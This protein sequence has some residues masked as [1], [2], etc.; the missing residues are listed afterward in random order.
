VGAI[1]VAL[2]VVLGL[3]GWWFFHLPPRPSISAYYYTELRNWFVGSMCA[4]GVFLIAYRLGKL[5]NVL[6][7]VAGVLAIVVGLV[8]VL[9]AKVRDGYNP[10]RWRQWAHCAC[11]ALIGISVIGS[12]LFIIKTGKDV[13]TES[14]VVFLFEALGVLAFGVSWFMTGHPLLPANPIIT[15]DP[16]VVTAG[17][18]SVTMPVRATIQ[19]QCYV[20]FWLSQR[21]DETSISVEPEADSRAIRLLFTAGDGQQHRIIAAAP[22]Y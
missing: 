1:G 15:P 14:F 18:L 6:A 3:G 22:R 7:T 9:F 16:V 10:A 2:P 8:S 17:G 21:L 13:R 4:F 5:D 11:G 12:A 20:R 19:Q